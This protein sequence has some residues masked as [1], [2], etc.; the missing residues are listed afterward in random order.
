MLQVGL[1][2]CGL[3]AALGAAA[4]VLMTGYGVWQAWWMGALWMIAAASRTLAPPRD[5]GRA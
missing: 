2:L 1:E 5:T 3:G 4:A